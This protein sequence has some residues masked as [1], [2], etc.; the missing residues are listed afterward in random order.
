MH[1]IYDETAQQGRCEIFEIL[2]QHIKIIRIPWF[3]KNLSSFVSIKVQFYF[4]H[5]VA[6]QFHEYVLESNIIPKWVPT[7][8]T[9]NQRLLLSPKLRFL[10]LK[11]NL[12]SMI[13]LILSVY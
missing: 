5:W 12:L 2:K 13:W 9:L 1:L 8:E 10:D 11:L 7:T 3:V 4:A 6:T